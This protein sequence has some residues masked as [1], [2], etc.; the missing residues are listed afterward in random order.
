MYQCKLCDD[1]VDELRYPYS[2]N[3]MCRS[4]WFWSSIVENQNEDCIVIKGRHYHI[5]RSTTTATRLNGFGG[6]QFVIRKMDGQQVATNN[7]WHQGEVPQY[8]RAQLPDNAEFVVQSQGGPD[9]S[10]EGGKARH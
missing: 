9:G 3:G 10:Q 5:G 6:R 8:F 2:T 7:L 4:C 1:N